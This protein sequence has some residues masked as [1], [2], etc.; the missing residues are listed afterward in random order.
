MGSFGQT[1]MKWGSEK[2]TAQ[3]C[4]RLL[5]F[6]ALLACT[7]FNSSS[8]MA[9]V[10]DPVNLL[11][12]ACHFKT[13]IQPSYPSM[14][15]HIKQADCD[16][17]PKASRETVW[18]S[19]DVNA[20]QPAA[21]TDY[22]L[23][24]YR[25]W[26]ERAI[27][28]FHYAD[29]H[30]QDYDVGSYEF[31]NYWSVGNLITFPAPAR[32]APVSN[33]LVGLQNASSIKLFHQM[34]FVKTEDWQ[35]QQTAGRFLTVLIT[36]ILLAMLFY[37]LALAALLRFSFHFHYILAV[38]AALAYNASA[39]GFM[40]YLVPGL[41]SHGA[42]MNISILAL[43]LNGLAGLLFLCSFLEE[44][45]LTR[46][47]TLIARGLGF[48]FFGLSIVFVNNRG[49]YT[50]ML[51]QGLHV[52]SFVGVLFIIAALVRA[53]RLK[54]Q[55]AWFYMVGWFLPIVG[56]IV[57]NMREFGI[58][59]HSDLVGYSIS[60]GIA[61]ETIV[62]AVGVA[63]RI[64]KIMTER[65]Q[66]KLESAK[67]SAASQAKS[68]FL[69][70]FSH[71]VRN[72]MNA[73]IGLSELAAKTDLSKEQRSYINNIQTSGSILMKLLNDT[74]DFSKIEAGKVS[75]EQIA[76]AP[77]DVL[78]NVRAVINPKAEG[79]NLTFIVEGE[80]TLPALLT[81]DPTRLS[82]VLINLTTNAV[83]FTDEG[84]VTL[85]LAA[86][87]SSERAISL[88][89]EVEDTG[90]G[91]TEEQVSGLFQSFRQADVSVTRKYGGTGLGLAISKQL[92]ELMG[93][94][95]RAESKPGI[96]SCFYVELPFGLPAVEEDLPG[97]GEHTVPSTP[98][99]TG[100]A[101]ALLEGVHIL[102]VEDNKINQMLV[103]KILEQTSA[104]FD[105]ASSGT[106][107]IEKVSQTRY[108]LILMD[109]N[110]PG[111]DGLETT[112][113]IRLLENGKKMP[114]I[115]MTGSADVGTQRNCLEAGMND[116]VTKPFKPET[117]YDTLDRWRPDKTGL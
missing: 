71:E 64:S 84:Q 59:P 72:P 81:G 101:T 44:G 33:I 66:A 79:K 51:E 53:L 62:L 14:L 86:S 87:P 34:S 32:E 45:I 48:L 35:S 54:S 94:D 58:I 73:I 96:G 11:P 95:I 49:P 77:K 37:N 109:L 68:D 69:A 1:S 13:E 108:D 102:I 19:L 22:V 113:A 97:P 56:V 63:H 12:S 29:G 18:L 20:A 90:I 76:F 61:L 16:T 41:I 82:Q 111:M 55:A 114:I 6:L 9:A 57:R 78:D 3:H 40:S 5:L 104:H 80:E 116:H 85:T 4:A 8:A 106:E 25:H 43:G 92:V 83:K 89:V 23:A 28:Q 98:I 46:W 93:G 107:A 75:I 60:V 99:P 105:F 24:I 74:L 65:D 42:Q 115:A 117:L 47:W 26:T 38:F 39:Y 67:A 15:S 2:A 112:K 88:C 21:N 100:G 27:I 30:M 103:T 36:G 91:M 7:G 50:E 31:D 17:R 110:L 10:A 52:V 70:H